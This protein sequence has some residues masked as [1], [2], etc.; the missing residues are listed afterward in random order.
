[1][2][3]ER[4]RYSISIVNSLATVFDASP[5]AFLPPYMRRKYA[6]KPYIHILF[7]P[8]ASIS[9]FVFMGA[10]CPFSD[11]QYRLFAYFPL[12]PTKK[13]NALGV[14]TS[15]CTCP[16]AHLRVFFSCFC[17]HNTSATYAIIAPTILPLW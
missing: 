11:E 4:G 8:K 15:P 16:Q 3:E 9:P 10:Y 1:M 14:F 12:H 17:F 6:A 2:H 7:S 13:G 5:V